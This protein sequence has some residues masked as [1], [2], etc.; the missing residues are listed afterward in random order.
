MNAIKRFFTICLVIFGSLITVFSITVAGDDYVFGEATNTYQE[1]YLQKPS[2]HQEKRRDCYRN[3]VNSNGALSQKDV[4][5]YLADELGANTERLTSIL[6][7]VIGKFGHKNNHVDINGMNPEL[8]RENVKQLIR[9]MNK[10]STSIDEVIM[11]EMQEGRAGVSVDF[12][13]GGGRTLKFSNAFFKNKAN[14]YVKQFADGERYQMKNKIHADVRSERERKSREG[15]MAYIT[16]VNKL[17]K[18]T[19]THEF[20]HSILNYHALDTKVKADSASG[21]V[22]ETQ[23]NIRKCILDLY[24]KYKSTY[25]SNLISGG[26]DRTKLSNREKNQQNFIS[27]YAG[28]SEEEF[29]AECF[30]LYELSDSPSSV[31]IYA[32]KLMEIIDTFFAWNPKINPDNFDWS[33]F[34]QSINSIK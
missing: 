18:Y 7:F 16:E 5:L 31:S 12:K 28:V 1:I 11:R 17:I 15:D 6:K 2:D 30:A 24:N 20:G 8:A 26:V 21:A 23:K 13:A 3:L 4:Y 19:V 22:D 34:K 9:L 10:Y 14:N 32:Q 25:G 27:E 29:I 33:A